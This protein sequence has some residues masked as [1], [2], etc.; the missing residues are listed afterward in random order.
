VTL[1]KEGAMATDYEQREAAWAKKSQEKEQAERKGEIKVGEALGKINKDINKTDE[2][3]VRIDNVEQLKFNP[4]ADLKKGDSIK[5][6]VE[7]DWSRRGESTR[8][9][10]GK[11]EAKAGEVFGKVTGNIGKSNDVKVRIDNVDQLKFKSSVD[12]KKG[13]FIRLLIEKV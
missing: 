3:K 1:G 11:S 2:M 12:L 6:I 8:G 10:E 5:I 4:F 7:A 9:H 13:D